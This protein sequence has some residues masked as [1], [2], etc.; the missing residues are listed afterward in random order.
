MLLE[1]GVLAITSLYKFIP[2][3]I[4]KNHCH[5]SRIIRRYLGYNH[6][7]DTSPTHHFT[8]KVPGMPPD[9]FQIHRFRKFANSRS[10]R[11]VN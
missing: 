2:L 3:C 9:I 1:I 10:L 6:V 8:C 5:H 7:F 11:T 4:T